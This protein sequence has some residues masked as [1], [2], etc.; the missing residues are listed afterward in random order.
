MTCSF[1]KYGDYFPGTGNIKDIGTGG[2]KFFSV[3]VPLNDGIDDESY[4]SIFKPIISKIMEVFRPSAVVL[5][6]GADSLTGDRLGCF[7]LSLKGHAECVEFVKG[8]DLP[9]LVLGGGGYTMRNVARCWA[10]ETSVICQ[11]TI[12]N[13]NLPYNDYLE[14]YGP[15]YKLHLV[16]TGMKN[17][18]S[19]E[20]LEN[21]KNAIL[22]N[23][24]QLK[25]APSVQMQEVPPDTYFED[26]EDED[27]MDPDER[28]CQRITDK[29]VQS[30]EEFYSSDGDVDHDENVDQ[31]E[32]EK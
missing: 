11:Q 28:E 6:C 2:G 8:F 16:P 15:D 26:S 1:H 27:E 31:M 7:N 20:Y 13:N 4:L 25:G 3:N 5:Q 21:Q 17:C 9:T 22:E 23:L 18:N 12:S 29:L 19:R 32:V 10:Y 30:T 14:Y 24:R